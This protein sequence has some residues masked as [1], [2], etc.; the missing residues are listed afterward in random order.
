MLLIFDGKPSFTAID[1]SHYQHAV[2]TPFLVVGDINSNLI[3][4]SSGDAWYTATD[5]I[6]PWQVTM[7]VPVDLVNLFPETTDGLSL[8]NISSATF[9]PNIVVAKQPTELIVSDGKPRWVT[10]SKGDVLYVQN[11]E[12][13]WLRELASGNMYLLLSGRWFRAKIIMGP[14]TF[15]RADELP[16]S[17]AEIPPASDIGGIRTSVAGTPEAEEAIL[18]AKIP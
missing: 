3:Y 6:G 14:W 9:V 12:M 16:K 18:D 17:F 5:P 13:P 1:N 2:N 8:S 7:S 15:V 4:L 10:L 11:T